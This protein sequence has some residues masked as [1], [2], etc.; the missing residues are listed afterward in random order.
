VPTTRGAPTHSSKIVCI[1]KYISHDFGCEKMS[2]EKST[3]SAE[4]RLC[5][6][7][8]RELSQNLDALKDPIAVRE[9]ME[10]LSRHCVLMKLFGQSKIK[11]DLAK[12]DCR[13]AVSPEESQAIIDEF[14]KTSAVN[15]ELA[16]YDA[17]LAFLNGIEANNAILKQIDN[18]SL[19]VL[20]EIREG[21]KKYGGVPE[22]S[23]LK[24]ENRVANMLSAADSLQAHPLLEKTPQFD[25]M[26]PKS[27]PDPKQDPEAAKNAAELQ[28]KPENRPD[29]RP[30]LDNRP[31]TAPRPIRPMGG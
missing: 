28:N 29:Y 8:L 26:P 22:T 14:G 7:R 27:N 21:E 19:V 20:S 23:L 24:D 5:C 16:K 25:G 17:L 1:L 18:G 6:L 4:K 31:S 12:S 13:L 3:D 2:L 15:A 11:W 10:I 30:S 9:A